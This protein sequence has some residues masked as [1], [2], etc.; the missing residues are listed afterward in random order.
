MW[1]HVRGND[2]DEDGRLLMG[3]QGWFDETMR[4]YDRYL[5]GATVP[6]DPPIA[7]ESS[8]GKWR[9]ENALAAGGRDRADDR[10]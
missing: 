6:D 8:D 1:D 10:R 9:A 2:T 3:R 4:F 7:V 5:K